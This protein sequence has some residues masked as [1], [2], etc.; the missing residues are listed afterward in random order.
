MQRPRTQR[1]KHT[2]VRTGCIVCK[3]RRIKCDETKP[4]CLR[5][6]KAGWDCE[7]Y[8]V[9]RTWLFDHSR[10]P[11]ELQ[12]E[13]HQ[14]PH[15]R[16]T[17]ETINV[18]F[19]VPYWRDIVMQI[20]Y[21]EYAIKYAV[22]TLASLH[23]TMMIPLTSSNF[24]LVAYT[25]KRNSSLKEC[26]RAICLLTSVSYQS[27]SL[28]LT[29]TSLF[30]SLET[31]HN[32]YGRILS[33]LHIGTNAHLLTEPQ[34]SPEE[35]DSKLLTGFHASYHE[36]AGLNLRSAPS[37]LDVTDA[38]HP[39]LAVFQSVQDAQNSLDCIS[40]QLSRVVISNRLTIMSHRAL[41]NQLSAWL[42]AVDQ[43]SLHT[44]LDMTSYGDVLLL[45]MRHTVA[46]IVL[47]TVQ[48]NNG[49]VYDQH[50]A[51]FQE[52]VDLCWTINHMID[53]RGSSMHE[54]LSRQ[55]YPILLFVTTACRDRNIRRSALS[56]L[57]QQ[58]FNAPTMTCDLGFRLCQHIVNIEES[59]VSGSESSGA[60][61]PETC[62]VRIAKSTNFVENR[63]IQLRYSR[64]PY[65]EHSVLEEEWV[66]C[67]S[68]RS[69]S[70][71]FALLSSPPVPT[72]VSSGSYK[73]PVTMETW[74]HPEMS[75]GRTQAAFDPNWNSPSGLRDNISFGTA[76]YKTDPV[77][78]SDVIPTGG[79][80]LYLQQSFPE[81]SKPGST[82]SSSPSSTPSVPGNEHLHTSPPP[83]PCSSQS[84]V[85]DPSIGA[86]AAILLDLMPIDPKLL[87]ELGQNAMDIP[88]Q[89]LEDSQL[90]PSIAAPV[91]QWGAVNSIGSS[92]KAPLGRSYY[93]ST[94][95][96]RHIMSLPF[97]FG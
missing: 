50:M 13:R 87:T 34:L 69:P 5:C 18:L 59:E 2:K 96:S 83:S 92:T 14:H 66:P 38:M 91:G 10:S 41:E 55:I 35:I 54:Q 84:S 17:V 67:K 90:K 36:N 31:F 56:L 49:M 71:D 62:R 20:S 46:S 26:S 7:G 81:M 82:R 45:R 48:S 88:Q 12:E 70:H 65:D 28:I 27:K 89:P 80:S 44:W 75:T 85:L 16:K 22:L 4:K 43:L 42:S 76:T 25:S 23:E 47:H 53:E 74:A 58:S 32:H 78:Q 73:P 39:D 57:E 21:S 72:A 40:R 15:Q 77:T 33:H 3:K 86:A 51:Q 68:N 63:G 19:E 61:L 6:T 79:F 1:K 11:S 29:A 97:P 52:I 30:F 9:P 37:D 64:F 94:P 95:F 60:I 24:D 93:P 8:D